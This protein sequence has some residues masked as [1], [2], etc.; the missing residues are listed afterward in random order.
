MNNNNA[1]DRIDHPNEMKR[2]FVRLGFSQEASNF[3]VQGQRLDSL[4]SIRDLEEE[5]VVSLCKLCRKPGGS[6]PN[7]DLP[8][9]RDALARFTGPKTISNPGIPVALREELNFGLCI[10]YLQYKLMTSRNVEYGEIDEASVNGI[11]IFKKEVE[12]VKNPSMDEAPKLTAR[13][14]F[15]F[16]GDLRDFLHEHLGVISRRPLSYVVRKEPLVPEARLDPGYGERDTRYRSFKHEIE[17]R[18]P[19]MDSTGKE[20]PVYSQDNVTVW[21]AIWTIVKDTQYVTYVKPYM[22][23]QDGRRAF[24]ALYTTLLGPQAI[25]NHASTAENKLQSM[26]LDGTR[27]KNWNF[28]KYVIGH[29]EQ[30]IILEKLVEH[31]YSGIDENSKVRLFLQGITDPRLAVMKSSLCTIK[32]NVFDDVVASFRNYIETNKTVE[33]QAARTLNISQFNTGGGYGNRNDNQRS[34]K[35]GPSSDNYNE[36]TDYSKFKIDVRYYKTKE[37]NALKPGERNFLREAKRRD[38][39]KQDTSN[40]NLKRTNRQLRAKIAALTAEQLEDD[41]ENMEP[42]DTSPRKRDKKKLKTLMRGDA[43]PL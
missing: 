39:S 31:G 15:D 27:K 6:I 4:A 35:A 21:K 16:F 40:S 2:M 22:P 10:F 32:N 28:D 42:V 38:T 5:N 43:I 12:K 13:K 30:H 11:R 34:T 23:T 1:V 41:D 26:T 9:T 33:K 36:G 7:P 25:N 24:V 17:W 29:K 14:I 19:I 37:W 18:A 20:D 3:F 8:T